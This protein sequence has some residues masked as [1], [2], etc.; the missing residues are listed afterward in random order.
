MIWLAGTRLSEGQDVERQLD[1]CRADAPANLDVLAGLNRLT[2]AAGGRILFHTGRPETVREDTEA[3]LRDHNSV[4]PTW[5]AFFQGFT[6][7]A[8]GTDGRGPVLVPTH[9]ALDADA[10]ELRLEGVH[11]L[12]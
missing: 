2:L 3:W 10:G 4:D 11:P 6:L 1:R 5:R 8:N 9:F 7:A 12:R